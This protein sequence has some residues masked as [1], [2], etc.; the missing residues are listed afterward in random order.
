M[1][2]ER[3]EEKKKIILDVI[4]G[5]MYVPMKVKELAILLN[6]PKDRRE[7]LHHV[8]NIL[9]SEGK[10]IITKRGKIIT[11]DSSVAKDAAEYVEGVFESNQRGFGFVRVEGDDDIFIPESFV[12]GAMHTDRVQVKI[13]GHAKGGQKREGEVI[14]VLER[15]ATEIV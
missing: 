2:L 10:L 8:V 6:V 12:H 4:S 9:E 5:E 13:T 1:E 3:L 15:G 14:K 11:P 7:E